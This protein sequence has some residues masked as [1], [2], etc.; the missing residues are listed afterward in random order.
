MAVQMQKILQQRGW[1]Q[2]QD[3]G[4]VAKSCGR[5]VGFK[6]TSTDRS[7]LFCRQRQSDHRKMADR[8]G[9]VTAKGLKV[10]LGMWENG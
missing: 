10:A 3:R 5:T 1:V 4:S 9:R 6:E 2:K 8:R 7:R